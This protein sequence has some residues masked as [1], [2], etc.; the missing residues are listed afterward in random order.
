MNT[1][2][3]IPVID[4]RSL[5][6]L[7]E[8]CRYDRVIID[9]ILEGSFGRAYA[10]S[11]SAPTVSRLDSGSFTV[12]AGDPNADAAVALV[13]LAPICYVTPQTD[14]WRAA[15][16]Q[17]FGPDMTVLSFTDF[18]H[19][20][21]DREHLVGLTE[22][23]QSSFELK[24][25]DRE[26]AEVMTF[27]MGNEYFFENF[28]SITDFLDRGMGYCIVHRNKIV[29]CAMSMARS[30]QA[31]DID[32]VT[33]PDHRKQ[34]LA[35]VAAARLVL[36]CLEAGIEPRWLAANRASERLAIKLGYL[37][38]ESYETLAIQH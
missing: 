23:L 35:T 12:L 25:I 15:L 5:K 9:G 29:S 11:A 17:E 36:R 19:A 10:D 13:R 38:G 27:Q 18:S 2:L 6:V 30:R 26:L 1:P 22:T 34:G 33:M 28:N 3:E 7:F 8:S 31:I 37:E 4:R 14:E 20:E 21:L 32:I 16:Q 24:A